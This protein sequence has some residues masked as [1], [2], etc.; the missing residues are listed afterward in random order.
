MIDDLYANILKFIH[1]AQCVKYIPN[2][3]GDGEQNYSYFYKNYYPFNLVCK[4][5]YLF[6]KI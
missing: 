5:W 1:I 4:K 6:Y 2:H 3:C